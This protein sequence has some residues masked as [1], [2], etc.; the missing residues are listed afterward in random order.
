MPTR[1]Y[2]HPLHLTSPAEN[3]GGSVGRR[4]DG[5]P[6]SPAAMF[7]TLAAPS[8]FR[9]RTDAE[10]FPVMPGRL[11]RIEWHDGATLAVCTD[12]PRLF[13]RLWA[14][15]HVRRW[16]VGDQEVRGLI[17]VSA[18]PTVADLIQARRWRT[19]SSEVARK[20]SGLP[21]VRASSVA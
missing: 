19:L 13:A 11:G 2:P 21:T 18:L 12:R 20:R 15:P 5:T 4:A 17:S 14:L 16:Q 1:P 3:S 7:R 10:G 6:L 9:V 8:R